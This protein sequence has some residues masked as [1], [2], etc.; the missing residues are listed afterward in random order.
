[1]QCEEFR[2][3]V[4]DLS[5]EDMIRSQKQVELLYKLNH[6][7]PLSEEYSDLLKELLEGHIGEN[8][9]I[10]PPFSGAAFHMLDIGDNVFIASNCLSMSRGGITIED[11]AMLAGNVQLLSNNHDE[12]KRNI[13]TC[14]PIHIKKGA[15]IGAGASILPGVCIGKY[16]IVGAGSIVT[17]DVPDYGVAVGSPARVIKSLDKEKFND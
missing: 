15:W 8:S 14:K 9:T 6:T 4:T 5:A 13:L 3:D 16:A 2:V 11:D 7:M 1:M 12:Y 17:K 10:Q